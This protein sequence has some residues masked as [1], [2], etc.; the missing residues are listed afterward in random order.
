MLVRRLPV[1]KL[2]RILL[3]LLSVCLLFSLFARK[4][5]ADPGVTAKH[6]QKIRDATEQRKL[7]RLRGYQKVIFKNNNRPGKASAS[8]I[9]CQTIKALVSVILDEVRPNV[10]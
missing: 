10:A 2:V 4:P 6:E 1:K 9:I 8:T 3:I 5:S 7:E